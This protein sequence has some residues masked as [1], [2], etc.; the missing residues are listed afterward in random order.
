MLDTSEI[1]LNAGTLSPTPASV[2][3]RA[4]T[5]RVRQAS[6][7]STFFFEESQGLLKTSRA[8]LAKFLGVVP[9]DLFLLPNVTHAMALAGMAVRLKAGDEVLT[10]NLEYGA[11]RLMWD[12]VARSAGA[13]IREVKLPLETDDDQLVK[14]ITKQITRRTRVLFFSHVSSLTGRVLPAKR[15]T[16]LG[17]SKGLIVVIDGAH[18]PGAIEVDVG[19]IAADAYGANVHKW[20]MGAAGC[21]FLRVST[22][23]KSLLEPLVPGW[24]ED[25]YDPKSMDQTIGRALHSG[26]RSQFRL[27]YT[28]VSDRVAQMVMPE[29]VAFLKKAD[30]EKI[31]QRQ[32]ELGE[33]CEGL[34]GEI[35]IRAAFTHAGAVRPPMMI[36]AGVRASIWQDL[37][38]KHRIRCPVIRW[39]GRAYLRVSTAWWNTE[40]ELLKLKQGL[41]APRK[42]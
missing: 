37:W 7:P 31:R 34:L 17:K 33:L 23:L 39:E 13:S 15:L 11:T 40:E 30:T 19:D 5:L 35:G 32:H 38:A 8:A 18:A 26:T 16:N 42:R 14:A 24:G 29:V 25:M 27:E 28:G 22:R 3:A 9:R 12:R 10:T 4:Q 2:F 1:N 6:A 41:Q 20:M 21:G 36:Y